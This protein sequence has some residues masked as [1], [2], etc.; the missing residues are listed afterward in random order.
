MIRLKLTLVC[1]SVLLAGSL[2][3]GAVV[4]IVL[5]GAVDPIRAGFVIHS[6]QEAERRQAACILLEMDTPGGFGSSMKD[7][8]RQILN[9][10]V[11]VVTFVSP[12]GAHAASAGFLILVS[13]D[14]AAMADGTNTG[15]AHPL[16]AFGG[17]MPLPEDEKMKPLLQKVQN[18][19]LAYL[20]GIVKER[21][22]NEE[23]ATLAV[24]ESASYTAREA[25]EKNLIDLVVRDEGDLLQKLEGRKVKLFN[26]REITL[27]IT[28]QS[29][30]TI[31]MTWREKLLSFVSNPDLAL[32]GI[33]GLFFEFSH[34]GFIA[35]GVIGGICLVLALLGFSLLPIN[36]VGVILL[37]LAI[38]LFV[39]EI[40]MQG[41]GILGIGGIICLILGFLMLVK[42]P[43]PGVSI[44]P[45]IIWGIVL[46]VGV[47]LLLLSRLVIRAMRRPTATGREGMV[48]EPGEAVN[49]L[50]PRGRIFSHGEYWE[51][52]SDGG[53]TIP[54]KTPVIVTRA[55][56]LKLYVKPSEN[57]NQ[58]GGA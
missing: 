50:T 3:R 40:K 56:G 37:I 36:Y 6:M 44:D 22:R 12:S 21:G 30:E 28:G 20:R 27:K 47:V 32:V 42:S 29:V 46:P 52:E 2:C 15:A 7:I 39:A 45:G 53:Q 34:P 48:G 4:R 13:A 17:V 38:G 55:E 51:A 10:R 23:A 18:D 16:L 9:S 1:V 31:E 25:L 26:G 57:N 49:D 43:D 5:D 33:L 11:P 54:A 41:F 24:T 58:P 14:V 35:P 8:I 19:I